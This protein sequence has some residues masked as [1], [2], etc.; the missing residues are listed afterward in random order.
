[1][2]LLARFASQGKCVEEKGTIKII[3][4]LLNYSKVNNVT[5]YFIRLP[6]GNL[7]GPGFHLNN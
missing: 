2:F 3:G 7:D 1:M 5:A 6:D 4:H